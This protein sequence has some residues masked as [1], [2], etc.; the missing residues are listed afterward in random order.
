MAAEP[1]SYRGIR[2]FFFNFLYMIRT[3][4][5]RLFCNLNIKQ[6]SFLKLFESNF[7]TY[8]Y[9]NKF[10]KLAHD[11]GNS[12]VA[13][14]FCHTFEMWRANEL[15]MQRVYGLEGRLY[16]LGAPQVLHKKRRR[17][18]T[19]PLLNK[20][21]FG[22]HKSHCR[23]VVTVV[24]QHVRIDLIKDMHRY[25]TIGR[26]HILVSLFEQRIKVLQHQM[27]AQQCVRQLVYSNQTIKFL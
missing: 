26:G 19:F 4:S 5:A 27:L 9:F 25:S 3:Y 15:C 17:L 14:V 12:L 13:Q 24:G 1:Y 2:I 7:L 23:L 22:R 18:V 8:R 16:S 6:L 11:Q 21:E 20:L 10:K